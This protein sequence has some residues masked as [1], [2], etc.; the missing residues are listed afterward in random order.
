MNYLFLFNNPA[1]DVQLHMNNTDMWSIGVIVIVVVT[2]IYFYKKGTSISQV[3]N[4]NVDELLET[5][6]SL[7]TLVE[8][9]SLSF[10]AIERGVNVISAFSRYMFFGFFELIFTFIFLSFS[11]SIFEEAM[12]RIAADGKLDLKDLRWAFSALIKTIIL[13]LVCSIPTYV[14]AQLYFQSIGALQFVHAPSW[15]PYN[16]FLYYPQPTGEV[17]F[18]DLS[19]IVMI[20]MTPVMNVLNLGYMILKKSGPTLKQYKKE[21]A[22]AALKTVKDSEKKAKEEEKKGKEIKKTKEE[23][24]TEKAAQE[25]SEKYKQALTRT[26]S[27]LNAIFG[28][29]GDQSIKNI[30]EAVSKYP[31]VKAAKSEEEKQKVTD[32]EIGKVCNALLGKAENNKKEGIK[33]YQAV[34]TIKKKT[35]GEIKT[36]LKKIKALEKSED[37]ETDVNNKA[38]LRK[39]ITDLQIKKGELRSILKKAN[40]DLSTIKITLE[41]TAKS[42]KVLK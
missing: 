35:D 7:S 39:E 18:I 32:R 1:E 6:A 21:A 42:M 27:G 14:I 34:E 4:N 9:L 20:Y 2:A 29:P 36:L 16:Q 38:E 23:L 3:L 12:R 33:G 26:V 41:Q 17:I 37:S 30:K 10:T 24:D 11:N 13:F 22:E 8:V 15:V 31:P 25:A 40:E 19:A 5:L 28:V